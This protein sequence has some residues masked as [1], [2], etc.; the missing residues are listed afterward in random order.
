MSKQHP[1]F[2]KYGAL[3]LYNDYRRKFDDAL[4]FTIEMKK[5]IDFAILSVLY[6]II[7]YVRRTRPTAWLFHISVEHVLRPGCSLYYIAYIISY[8]LTHSIAKSMR[9]FISIVNANALSNVLR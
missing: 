3:T 2:Q 1:S 9:F 8:M 5:R 6:Y 4:A 7:S